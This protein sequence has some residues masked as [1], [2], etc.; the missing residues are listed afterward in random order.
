[1]GSGQA[2]PRNRWQVQRQCAC[3]PASSNRVRTACWSALGT[4]S[5]IE[6][7]KAT[8]VVIDSL[9]GLELTLASVFREDFR[10]SLYR[11]V[12][13]LT[14][15][16][17]TVLM[18]AELE[19]QYS[20]LRFSTYGNAFL[21]DAIVM[22]RYV[23]LAGQLKRVISVIKVRGSDHSKDIRF[24]D[25]GTDQITIGATLSEYQGI[26]SGQPEVGAMNAEP[27]LYG[28]GRDD[29]TRQGARTVGQPDGCLLP[30][31]SYSNFCFGILREMVRPSRP[32]PSIISR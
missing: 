10:E 19:D 26:L 3:P 30:V 21:V 1:M 2:T 31:F 22:H 8:R 24:F 16:G 7:T 17:V 4:V 6:R 12:A 14:G 32:R 28:G 27:N 29:V 15:L 25:I 13:V 20:A 18:T 23:E 5:L 9:A 11:L